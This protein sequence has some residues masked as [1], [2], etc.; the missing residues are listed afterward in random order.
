MA[1]RCSGLCLNNMTNNAVARSAA[2]SPRPTPACAG[3]TP[4]TACPTHAR[5]AYPRLRGEHADRHGNQLPNRGLPPLARGTHVE[6]MTRVSVLGPTPACAGNTRCNRGR[7]PGHVAYPRL[8]GEHATH[9]MP[10]AR[11]AGLPPLARGTRR[12]PW[13]SATESRPTPACAG[14]TCRTDDQGLGFGAYPR[15]R[16]E[17]ALQPRQ[18]SRTCGL[19]PLARGTLIVVSRVASQPRPTPACAGNT[20]H[21]CRNLTAD[22]AYPRLRGEHAA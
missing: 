5:R 4:L 22:R 16:G 3:N 14:N 2:R 18:M 6:R 21:T 12:P 9:C 20:T 11:Q 15:L 7:C 17:H 1:A 10:D 19:P 13:Q 8:R